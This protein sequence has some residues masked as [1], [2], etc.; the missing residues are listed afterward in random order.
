M[1]VLLVIDDFC[2]IRNIAQYLGIFCLKN[3]N[4]NNKNTPSSQN[5]KKLSCQLTTKKFKKCELKTWIYLNILHPPN[6]NF[7]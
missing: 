1:Q 4:N 7:N 2:S 6:S 5:K 3:N